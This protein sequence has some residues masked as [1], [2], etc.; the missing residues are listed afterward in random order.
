MNQRR[1][2]AVL[3]YVNII[4][5][6]VVGLLYT[7]L[8]LRLLGQ[9]EY[10]LYSLIGSVVGYLSVLDM[11][12]GNTLVRYTAKNRVDGTTQREAEMNGLFLTMYS[13]IGI[14]TF[15]VGAGIYANMDLLFGETLDAGEMSRARIMM[16]LLIFNFA[17]SF[18]FSIFASVLQ[19]YEKFIFLR[20]SNILRVVLNP[21]LVL[22]FLYWGYGSVMMVVV[23]TLLNFACLFANWFYCWRYLL[24][25]FKRG[26]FTKPF[27]R[28]VVIYSFFIFLN[29]IMDKIYWGTGQ[30]VLGIVSGTVQ[31]AVYAIAMQ[32]MMMFMNFSNAISGVLLPK[33]TMM[34]TNR[35]STKEL[36]ALM[37]RIGR[38][39][40]L[41]VGYLF[42][43]FLLVGEDFIRLWA[44]DGYVAAYPIVLLLMAVM[45]VPLVQNVGITILQA[46]N[47][48]RYRMTAYTICAFIALLVS[49]PLAKNYGGIGCAVATAG[50]L[51]ISTGVI[52]N[53]YYAQK[54]KLDIVQFW[55]NIGGM[56][57]GMLLLWILVWS[58]KN[59]LT[60]AVSW[61]NFLLMSILST[62]LY[63]V[64]MYVWCMNE[65]ERTLCRMA[66]NKLCRR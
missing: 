26:H 19:A 13:V 50:S 3:S 44:G 1:W 25:K 22:P 39:Q 8:M 65:N 59:I 60:V 52:M 17:L 6:V 66:V 53:R 30:F 29:A 48:N 62:F 51:L 58:V 31:V 16:V 49:F 37:I 20:V 63:V 18:P 7:P 21:L 36:T 4:L 38:L 2:G 61:Q 9:S 57:K 28:E 55:Q 47:L 56:S 15:I 40:Y 23:S 32:F 12:L 64:I 41:V 10:G 24:V 35:V 5:T 43:M 27:L 14:I 34:V 45:L 42:V 46:M 11:G 54:V 33:V